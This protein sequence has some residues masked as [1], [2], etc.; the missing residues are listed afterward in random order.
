[1][2]HRDRDDSL[3]ESQSHGSKDKVILTNKTVEAIYI[4]LIYDSR[5]AE[6]MEV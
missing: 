2:F 5:V 6:V 4:D 1:M 3:R